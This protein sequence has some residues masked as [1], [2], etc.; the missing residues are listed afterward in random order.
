[1]KKMSVGTV[2]GKSEMGRP[3]PKSM[4]SSFFLYKLQ[5]DGA[6]RE[7]PLVRQTR[8]SGSSRSRPAQIE[9]ELR[10]FARNKMGSF[11]ELH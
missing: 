9:E 4:S 8:T 6:Q 11:T 7:G 3:Q 1:V 2:R 10:Y 5:E